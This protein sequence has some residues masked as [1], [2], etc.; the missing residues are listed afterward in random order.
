[1]DPLRDPEY[2][3]PTRP[4]GIVAVITGAGFTVRL[5]V[6][7]LEVPGTAATATKLIWFDSDAGAA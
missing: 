2:E 1:L 6:L 7:L 3:V 5:T 4:L